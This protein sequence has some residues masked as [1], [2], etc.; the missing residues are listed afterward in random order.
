MVAVTQTKDIGVSDIEDEAS[1]GASE[2]P[3]G[4]RIAVTV[5]S[6]AAPLI[7]RF[8]DGRRADLVLLREHLSQGAFDEIRKVAHRLKGSGGFY[9]FNDISTIGATLEEAA[10]AQ[11]AVTVRRCVDDLERY[12]A[13]VDVVYP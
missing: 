5:Q 2:T 7:P 6:W 12:L 11:D 1:Q 4:D 9:G 13:H 8:L 10:S 3:G